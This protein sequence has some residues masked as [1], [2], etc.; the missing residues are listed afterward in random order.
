[1]PA[2]APPPQAREA[3]ETPVQVIERSTP[4]YPSRARNNMNPNRLSDQSVKLRVFVDPSGR[5]QKVTILE[6]PSGPWGYEDA[7]QEAALKSTF[8]P[9]TKDGRP[10]GGFILMSFTFKKVLGR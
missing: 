9:A 5:P 10:V 6:G 4:A 2:P 8:T 1:M 7:A 3:V